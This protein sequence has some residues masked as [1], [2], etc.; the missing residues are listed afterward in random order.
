MSKKNKFIVRENILITNSIEIKKSNPIEIGSPDW[1]DWLIK[2]HGFKYEGSTGHFTARCELRRGIGYWYA[3]RRRDGKLYKTYLGKSEELDSDRLERACVRLAGQALNE[4]LLNKDDHE[5]NVPVSDQEED[6]GSPSAETLSKEPLLPLTKVKSPAMPQNL[7][8]RPYLIERI[9]ASVNIISAP[10]GFGK[11]TLLNEWQEN[12]GLQV[13]WVTLDAEDNTPQRFWSVVVTALQT[14][15]SNVGQGWSSELLTASSPDHSTIVFNLTND[16]IR[17]KEVSIASQGIALV[18]DNYHRV[19]N[20]EIHTSLQILL[21]HIPSEMKLIIASQTKPPLELGSLRSKGMVVELG[22]DDLRFSLE[23]GLEFLSQH[24]SGNRLA[25]GEMR[26]LVKRTE[27][28]ITGLVLADSILNQDKDL[29]RFVDS[30]NGAHPFLQEYFAENVLNHQSVE[31]QIF[32]IKT[33]ILKR[34]HGPLCD[35]IVGEKNSADRLAYLWKKKLFLERLDESDW[36]RYHGLFA[37]M[38]QAQLQEHYSEEISKL[39]HRAAEW[40]LANGAQAD[41]VHH[42]LSGNAWNEAAD[43][44]EGIAL[45]ELEKYGEGPRLLRW[46]QQLPEAILHTRKNLL[47]LYIRLAMLSLPPSEVEKILTHSEAT[48]A[49]ILS[50][51]QAGDAQETLYEIHQVHRLWMTNSGS[52]LESCPSGE[53]S[54]AYQLLDRIFQL[55]RG[56]TKNLVEAEAEASAVYETAQSK[57]HLY[58]ALIAGGTCANLAFSQGHLRRC[59]QITHQVL[60]QAIEL[61]DKLP[62]PASI[63]L[64]TLSG[65]YFERNQL[66]QAHQL[67]ERAIAVDPNPI[68]TYEPMIMAILRAKIQSIQGDNVSAFTTVQ[69]VRDLY[70]HRSAGTQLDQDLTAYQAL[71]RLQQGDIVSAE[72]Q[73]REGWEIER[74]PFSAFVQASILAEQNRYVAAEEILRNLLDLYP[75][76]FYWVPILRVHAK[77]ALVLF[78]QHKVNQASQVMAEAARLAAPEFFVRPFLVSGPQ[79]ASLLSLVLHT[80]NLNEGTRSFLKGILTMLGYVEGLQNI[81]PRDESVVLAIAASITPREQHMLRLLNASLSNQEIAEQ[82]SISPSTVKTHLENIYRKLGVNSR[83]QA[84]EQARMLNLV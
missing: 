15:G 57:G 51:G 28:W 80:E 26:K 7:I 13:A 62:E 5:D 39:H 46:L 10:S 67:L 64:T 43:L 42:F 71:F 55:G 2:N 1:N 14:I 54:A 78:D 77:L 29:S 12:C 48:F 66:A 34:L 16:L 65:V 30:F 81:L 3:H 31:M 22:I 9:G 61:R 11:T 82:C 47:L 76:G 4:E 17:E 21:D 36:F 27:G 83:T 32:L 44:I 70:S 63:A 19:Q 41:A 75:N 20:P 18:L 49:S 24:V 56:Y 8:S 35:A 84:V 37:E 45:N 59:E 40:Y 53:Y 58:A 60:R 69:A 38:L 52:S 68:G 72:Q 23:E 6:A 25:N 73:L 50:L 79:V 74:H 33:S